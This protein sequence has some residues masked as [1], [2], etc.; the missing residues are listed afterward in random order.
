[1]KNTSPDLLTINMKNLRGE[2]LTLDEKM[3]LWRQVISDQ[4]ANIID[5]ELVISSV[6][7]EKADITLSADI[8]KESDKNIRKYLK[9]MW[10]SNIDV[11]SDFPA[12]NESYTGTTTIKFNYNNGKNEQ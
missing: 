10:A 5:Q 12:Y 3:K 6:S 2:Q 4:V 1:M 9:I 8:C 11:T 7:E